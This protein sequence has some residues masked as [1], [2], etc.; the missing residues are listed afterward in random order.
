MGVI[1]KDCLSS[2][3][4][5]FSLKNQSNMNGVNGWALV[6]I[7]CSEVSIFDLCKMRNH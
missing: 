6:K 4:N 5:F 2:T 7:Q 3:T 1:I